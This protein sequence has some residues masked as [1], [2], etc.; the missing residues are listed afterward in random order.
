VSKDGRSVEFHPVAAALTALALIA[1]GY[2]APSFL[3]FLSLIVGL[4]LLHEGGHWYAA[5]RC[6]MRPTEFFV[7]FGPVVVSWQRGTCVYGIKA[8]P[9][10]G[11]VK[12]PGMTPS[13]KVDADVEPYT[14]RAAT[15]GRRL[16]VVLAGVTVNMVVAVVL[17]GGANLVGLPDGHGGRQSM[18]PVAAVSDAAGTTAT[19][20]RTTVDGLASLAG[21]VPSYLRSLANPATEEPPARFLSPVGASQVTEDAAGD[22]IT[23]LI[24]FAAILSVSLAVLN[25]LPLLPLD[26]GHAAI[27]VV[28]GMVDAVQ[29]RRRGVHAFRLDAARFTPVAYTVVIGLL[30]LSA[31]SLWLDITNP[32]GHTIG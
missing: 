21:S 1:I 13:E 4:I 24:R 20:A 25:V 31:S 9:A 27:V 19:V 23:T 8:I 10:G 18:D 5:R 6:G 17:F 30:L 28:E 16:V 3:G 32:L 12:I 22:D 29:R 7:G 2:L 11:Y 15:R 26:G 14:Y